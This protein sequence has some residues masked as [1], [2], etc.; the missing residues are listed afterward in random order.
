MPMII[1]RRGFVIYYNT[2]NFD[3]FCVHVLRP[4][5]KKVWKPKDS[6]YFKWLRKVGKR[7][8]NEEVYKDFLKLYKPIT[9]STTME[10]IEHIVRELSIKYNNSQEWWVILALTIKAEEHKENAILGKQIKHLAV[11]NLLKENLRIREIVTYMKGK[12]WYEL[13]DMMIERDIW[14][15]REEF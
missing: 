10:D 11:F 14:E 5:I 1:T 8:G 15:E 4:K 2:G 7:Y 13:R 3:D 6:D 12:P 9:R